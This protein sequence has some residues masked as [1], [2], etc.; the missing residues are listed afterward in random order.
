MVEIDLDMLANIR[1]ELNR[2]T[3]VPNLVVPDPA[4]PEPDL[5]ISST[6]IALPMDDVHP[7]H[8]LCGLDRA[9]ANGERPEEQNNAT[10]L[11]IVQVSVQETMQLTVPDIIVT[12]VEG[13]SESQH[14]H[15]VTTEVPSIIVDPPAIEAIQPARNRIISSRVV[16]LYTSPGAPELQLLAPSRCPE[17]TEDDAN[18]TKMKQASAYGVVDALTSADV[19]LQVGSLFQAAVNAPRTSNHHND[20][21]VTVRHVFQTVVSKYQ[22]F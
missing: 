7:D 4:V 5:Q 8:D 17:P 22:Y 12:N 16:E 15:A 3:A 2:H 10:L 18:E 19:P 1:E 9:I 20:D 11:P 21:A 14:I 13:E 6:S